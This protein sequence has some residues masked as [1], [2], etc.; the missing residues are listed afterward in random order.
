MPTGIYKR[1]EETRK[2]L[3][4]AHTGKPS[5]RKGQ[6]IPNEV[7]KKI[8]IS[9]MGKMKGIKKPPRTKEHSNKIS[10]SKLGK[11]SWNKNKKTGFLVKNPLETRR[12]MSEAHKGEKSYLW[13]GGLTEINTVIRHSLEYKLWREAVFARDNYTCIW[14]GKEHGNRLNADHIKSF[15]QFPEL[16]FAIDNGR[17]LCVGCHRNTDTYGHNTTKKI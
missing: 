10:L 12:R 4:L 14:G 7:R 17:T 1:T 2:I 3:S 9:L 11:P 8:S 15:A 16:R 13:K 5:G 6:S